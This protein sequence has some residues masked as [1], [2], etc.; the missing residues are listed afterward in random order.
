MSWTDWELEDDPATLQAALSLIDS[1]D[2]DVDAPSDSLTSD[3]RSTSPATTETSD[4][5]SETKKAPRATVNKSRDRRKEELAYLRDKVQAMEE[6]LASLKR[7]RHVEEHEEKTLDHAWKDM[8]RRQKQQRLSADQE[9]KQLRVKLATQVK[10]GRELMRLL[11]KSNRN[12][13]ERPICL[14][15]HGIDALEVDIPDEDQLA[16]VHELYRSASQIFSSLP[17][18]QCRATFRDFNVSEDD[19]LST[20]SITFL[21]MWTLPYAKEAIV[22]S[23]WQSFV[24]TATQKGAVY[25][26]DEPVDTLTCAFAKDAAQFGHSFPGEIRGKLTA[27]NFSRESESEPVLVSHVSAKLVQ[28]PIQSSLVN[29]QENY[30][31]RVQQVSQNGSECVS[32]IQ[33]SRKIS[34]QVIAEGSPALSRSVGL[35]TD[36]ALSQ[37]E[38]EF[39]WRQRTID[40]LLLTARS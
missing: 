19:A 21:A 40:N 34:F 8:A 32:Q 2:D 29:F 27:K 1:L 15:G 12:E 3:T 37:I 23:A 5:A 22:Q 4:D 31:I 33:I 18:D 36:F 6:T 17:T 11:Q 20:T 14:T 24:H 9:N 16:R 25:D 38:D 10:M 28:S 13:D 7:R 35:L 39:L 26:K 30:C